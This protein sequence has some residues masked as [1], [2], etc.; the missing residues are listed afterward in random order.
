MNAVVILG[1]L[2]QTGHEDLA[3]AE[4]VLNAHGASV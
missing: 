3:T 4:P 2:P 1:D